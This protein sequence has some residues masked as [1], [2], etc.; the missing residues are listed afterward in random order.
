MAAE[1][2]ALVAGVQPGGGAEGD[3]AGEFDAAKASLL[4]AARRLVAVSHIIGLFLTPPEAASASDNGMDDAMQVIIQVRQHLRKKKDFES[5]DLI[6]D[7]LSERSIVLEDRPDGT[8]W[9]R[10]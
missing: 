1:D 8:L 7:L 6:R 5:A 4:G 3:A 9:R 2:L 10:E